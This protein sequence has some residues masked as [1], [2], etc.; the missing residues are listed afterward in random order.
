MRATTTVGMI[1][2]TKMYGCL[3]LAHS[4]T[5][6]GMERNNMEKINA[7]EMTVLGL[8]W[9]GLYDCQDD[10]NIQ[11]G[12]KH[13]D[14]FVVWRKGIPYKVS[15]REHEMAKEMEGEEE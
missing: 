10:D 8:V 1:S 13:G 5:S 6:G 4:M 9:Q 15:V 14:Y 7:K 11:R 3:T 12:L 2:V